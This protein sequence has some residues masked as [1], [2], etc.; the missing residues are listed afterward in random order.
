MLSLVPG[1]WSLV[2]G[3]LG[4]QP[5]TGHMN[6][7]SSVCRGC[8][9][10]VRMPMT[11]QARQTLLPLRTTGLST[12]PP[13]PAMATA[14]STLPSFLLPRLSWTA[15]AA[16]QCVVTT[17]A[18]TQTSTLRSWQS[19]ARSIHNHR[20]AV[21]HNGINATKPSHSLLQQ[22][23]LRRAFH[24]S[25]P[26]RRDH[27]FD[28]LKFVQRL[29]GEG[30]TEEQSVAMMKVLNDVIEERSEDKYTGLQPRP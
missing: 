7:K 25:A 22:P 11:P 8:P 6:V 4:R 24:A 5:T 30:F 18:A 29:Q 14:V 28:T 9:L 19:P 3:K 16:R 27:H 13:L 1:P 17:L 21:R 20:G 23:G 10:E 12:T 15:P 2:I 26:R